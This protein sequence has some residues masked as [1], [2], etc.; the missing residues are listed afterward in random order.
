MD[1]LIIK[2]KWLGMILDG[3]KDMEIRGQICRRTGKTIYLLES[4]TQTARATA[5]I[6]MSYQILT[7]DTWQLY[8]ARHCVEIDFSA[9]P[10]SKV[11]GWCLGSVK[12]IE[13]FRYEH[14]R[15]AVICGRD[16]EKRRIE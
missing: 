8:R 7:E 6:Y 10:Y 4:G 1:G 14:P 15:G 2:P 16:V 3:R 5:V 12:A 13:P 9:V 11:Y